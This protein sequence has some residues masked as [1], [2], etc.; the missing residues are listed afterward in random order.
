MLALSGCGGGGDSTID[1]TARDAAPQATESYRVQAATCPTSFSQAADATSA[2]PIEFAVAASGDDGSS[3][4]GAEGVDVGCT[5]DLNDDDFPFNA[6]GI[7]FTV[8]PAGSV[9]GSATW[10]DPVGLSMNALISGSA[11]D[12]LD[13]ITLE[14]TAPNGDTLSEITLVRSPSA[15]G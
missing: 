1:D 13:E 12:A 14:L 5:S 3:F 10:S 15:G 9:I 11:N 7:E 6:S 4:E 2:G 8:S